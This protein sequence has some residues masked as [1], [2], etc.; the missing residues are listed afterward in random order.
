MSETLDKARAKL[1]AMT[2]AERRLATRRLLSFLESVDENDSSPEEIEREL[3][4]LGIDVEQFTARLRE[5][6]GAALTQP[7]P[8]KE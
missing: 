1:A 8:D 7:T 2:P 4:S 3:K 6:I 5:R